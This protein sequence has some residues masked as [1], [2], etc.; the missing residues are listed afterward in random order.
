MKGEAAVRRFWW[1]F[2]VAVL[3]VMFVGLGLYL[4]ATSPWGRWLGR[5]PDYSA[6]MDEGDGIVAAIERFKA[7]RGLWPEYLD[8]LT[9]DYLKAAPG[10]EWFYELTPVGEPGAT[11]AG[12]GKVLPSLSRHAEGRSVRAHV[13]YDFDPKNPAWRLFGDVADDEE[14]VLRAGTVELASTRGATMP[15]ETVAANELAELDRRIKREPGMVEHWQG[16]AGLLRAL[17]RR[18]DA[19]TVVE[20]AR[21]ALPE[22][23]WPRMAVAAME[24]EDTKL[25]EGGAGASGGAA[26]PAAATQRG[27]EKWP[28]VEAFAEWV[29]T[30]PGLTHDY[31]LSVLYRMAGEEDAAAKAMQAAIDEP[32]ELTA[33]DPYV[34]SYYFWDMGRWAVQTRRWDLA[35]AIAR[36]W[37]QAAKD[38]RTTD[39]SYLALR[40]AALLAQGAIPSA[41]KDLEA[42]KQQAHV[43]AKNVEGPGG[44]REAVERGDRAYGYK[45][46]DVPGEFAVF[47]MPE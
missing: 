41:Q 34:A 2:R 29:K 42:L 30:A 43:W 21:E 24:I 45:P 19:R 47:V 11:G 25:A 35:I 39:G 9:P 10:R 17:G 20:A 40:A 38:K 26:S 46:G 31:Y 1:W 36:A 3:S 27:A 14:R 16:K 32:V 13:G 8:D 5:A 44:L 15:A 28:S 12:G 33:D 22:S 18:Q 37:E 6:M 7:E 4:A 23:Y